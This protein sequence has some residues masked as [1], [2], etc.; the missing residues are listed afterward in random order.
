VRE[1]VCSWTK[2][3]LNLAASAG[4]EGKTMTGRDQDQP[5]RLALSIVMPT[6][7]EEFALHPTTQRLLLSAFFWTYAALQ[8]PGGG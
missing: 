5:D 1:T 7:A 2:S 3:S 8:V 6:I 4:T